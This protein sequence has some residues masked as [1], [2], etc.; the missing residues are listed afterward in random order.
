MTKPN[1]FG[2][3]NEYRWPRGKSGNPSGKPRTKDITELLQAF[4]EKK[5]NPRLDK[6]RDEHFW[7]GVYR[8]ACQGNDQARKLYASYRWGMPVQQQVNLNAD[9][10]DVGLAE[11]VEEARKRVE[12]SRVTIAGKLES[13][14]VNLLSGIGA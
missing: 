2:P 8:S 1:K 4:G 14:K 11:L 13:E 10:S 6:T 7:E 3:G 12:A 5:I 9:V